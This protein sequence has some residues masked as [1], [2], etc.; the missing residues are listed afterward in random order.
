MKIVK[1]SLELLIIHWESEK[2]FR[3]AVLYGQAAVFWSG[4]SFSVEKR[5]CCQLCRFQKCQSFGLK[6]VW[7]RSDVVPPVMLG[8]L[9]MLALQTRVFLKSASSAVILQPFEAVEEVLIKYSGVVL[10]ATFLLVGILCIWSWTS[11]CGSVSGF[12]PCFFC[13]RNYFF[14]SKCLSSSSVETQQ[15]STWLM[16]WVVIMY[17]DWFLNS[18]KVFN[19]DHPSAS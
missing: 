14:L 5:M 8:E 9:L 1:H 4:T 13:W 3:I 6:R 18:T 15:T 16:D 11:K 7:S 12:W 17:F 19:T 10:M 2:L